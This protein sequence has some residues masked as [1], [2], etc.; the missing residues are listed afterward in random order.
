MENYSKNINSKGKIVTV[1]KS[2]EEENKNSIKWSEIVKNND[3]LSLRLEQE[4][5]QKEKEKAEIYKKS[6]E[7]QRKQ[8]YMSSLKEKED[9]AL[10]ERNVL[11]KTIDRINEE[12]Y[13]EL[14]NKEIK[15]KKI[16]EMM[17]E[18]FKKHRMINE[19][20]KRKEKEEEKDYINALLENEK[21]ID[22]Q[23]KL[24]EQLRKKSE[25][26]KNE[27]N[28]LLALNRKKIPEV[29]KQSNKKFQNMEIQRLIQL[30]NNRK[31]YFEYLQ[32]FNKKSP[33]N[34]FQIPHKPEDIAVSGSD[35][36]E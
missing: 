21:A 35:E 27:F 19:E 33:P 18:N 34:Y 16:R 4:E 22:D 29:E 25:M 3:I 5:I 6:L 10:R 31:K 15:T 23:A 30:E 1:T 7:D 26:N 13:E 14:I 9:Q 8:N 20:R 11:Q 17:E 2:G 32:N 12:R 28:N 24:E 36:F